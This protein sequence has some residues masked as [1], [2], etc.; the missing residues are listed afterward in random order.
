MRNPLAPLALIALLPYACAPHQN[1]GSLAV[2]A[3]AKAME[4]PGAQVV[5]VRTPAE[6]AQGHL[7]GALALD[8]SGGEL[9]QG[10]QGL[11]PARPVL[12][13]C[14]SGNRSAAAREFLIDQGFTDVH[15]LEGG[16]GAWSRAGRPMEH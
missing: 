5:D 4:R 16:I 8:W 13:Y 7:S 14:A 1:G 6:Y 11:D 12:L 9:E 3:F 15:D 2:A 10:M